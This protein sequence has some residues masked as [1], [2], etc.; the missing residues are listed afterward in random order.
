MCNDPPDSLFLEVGKF[1]FDIIRKKEL[2]PFYGMFLKIFP[3]SYTHL[4]DDEPE[5]QDDYEDR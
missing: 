5:K 4:I 3:V 1:I 2:D